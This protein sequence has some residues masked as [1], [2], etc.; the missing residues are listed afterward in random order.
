MTTAKE[1]AKSNKPKGDVAFSSFC[2]KFLP[3]EPTETIVKLIDNRTGA[4]YCECHIKAGRLVEFATP[5]A[6]LDLDEPD[7]RANR[8]LVTN[9][10]AFETMKADAIARRSFSNIVTEYMPEPDPAR[11]LK[12]IGGQHRFDAICEA[13][14]HDVDEYHGV[15]VYFE[16]TMDQRLDVQ[17]ISN[18]NI[19]ISGDLFDRMQETVKGPELREWCQSV[20]LLESGTDFADRRVRGGPISVQMARTFVVNYFAGKKQDHRKFDKIETTPDLCRTGQRDEVWE[21]IRAENPNLWKDE[22]LR[23]AAQQFAALI[24]AQRD[25]FESASP[26]PKPDF[27]DKAMNPAVLAAWVY[28]AGALR[29]NQERLKRHFRLA[30]SSGHDPLNAAALA[31]GRHKTDPAN[32]RGLGY[33]TDAKERGR[34]VELFN[35]QAEHGKGIARATINAAIAQ[36]HAKQAALEAQRARAKAT[37][38]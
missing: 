20:G 25:A 13:H 26:K 16:L 5:D 9:A 23:E 6:P 38:G 21:E 3:L 32:Y 36:Y 19:A 17:L 29:S 7:Y 34:L 18:T 33:R 30:E 2:A 11:P 37:G 15:K 31:A 22:G 28:V 1:N 27:P 10:P 14:K 12:V 8:E 4:Q 35:F 24:K